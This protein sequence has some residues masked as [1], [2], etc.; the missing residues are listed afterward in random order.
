[1]GQKIVLAIFFVLI[2]CGIAQAV[3]KV[4]INTASV[5]ELDTVPEI[6]PAIAT[7]IVEY[8]EANGPFARIEDIVNVKGI[9]EA[10][11]LKM[12]DFIT[13]EGDDD[14]TV[15]TDDDDEEDD[16]LDAPSDTDSLSAHGNQAALSAA[17]QT[18]DPFLVDAGRPR[19]GSIHAPLKFQATA[20]AG[21]KNPRFTWS[22]GDGDS[23][24]GGKATHA[25][26]FPGTYQV[27][28]NARDPA[29]EVTGRTTVQVVEPKLK[30]TYHAAS[31]PRLEVVN[32]SS[33][34]IN[35]GGWQI[36]SDRD[37]FLIPADTIVAAGG[38]TVIPAVAAPCLQKVG[39]LWLRYPDGVVYRQIW[40][41]PVA[42]TP[43]VVAVPLPS[44]PARA[45]GSPVIALPP[46]ITAS[47]APV[48]PVALRPIEVLPPEVEGAGLVG[49]TFDSRPG[50]LRRGLRWVADL[51]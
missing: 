42:P 20:S 17:G 25:Y 34:E 3:A 22:F 26:L 50:L 45:S 51:F 9:G 35:L 41:A 32:Q 46:L 12:K 48:E 49:G 19:L 16:D 2:S 38:T 40:P 15:V 6:G 4:N 29:G 8:R 39:A 5:E 30:L 47:L 31:E 18:K 11:F 37:Y 14:S 33:Q 28:V 36:A 13:V 7:R 23:A 44:V 21:A 1:M 43:V 27:V 24:R 10:T